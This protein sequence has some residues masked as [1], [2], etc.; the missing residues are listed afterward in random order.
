MTIEF[1]LNGEAISLDAPEDTP[2]LWAI[3]DHVGLTGTKF[4]CG[5]GMCG[6]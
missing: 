1:Q 4:G 3:R 2:L 5:I 6:A